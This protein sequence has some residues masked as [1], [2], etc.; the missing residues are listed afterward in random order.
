MKVD[1]HTNMRA[2][3]VHQAN[4]VT[5]QLVNNTFALAEFAKAASITEIP[6][7]ISA[8]NVHMV[9]AA[10]VSSLLHFLRCVHSFIVRYLYSCAGGTELEAVSGYWSSQHTPAIESGQSAG[11]YYTCPLPGACLGGKNSSCKT[12][13]TGKVR[14]RVQSADLIPIAGVWP[15]QRR[16]SEERRPV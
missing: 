10:Q 6:A 7:K 13:Y 16:V 3:I 11:E 14:S 2:Q 1:P 4:L 5:A 15:L 8:W 12:G 9:R